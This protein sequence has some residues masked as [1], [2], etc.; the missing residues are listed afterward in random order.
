VTHRDDQGVV[1]TIIFGERRG[2][3]R[4]FV[5][6]TNV[7]EFCKRVG[8]LAHCK[9]V[10]P[11]SATH[12]SCVLVLPNIFSAWGLRARDHT[13]GV[14]EQPRRRKANAP[15]VAPSEC[16]FLGNLTL[17]SSGVDRDH[18]SFDFDVVQS[19]G[20]RGDFVGFLV[21]GKLPQA[22]RPIHCPGTQHRAFFN[23]RLSLRERIK[24]R[25]FR[26]AKDDTDFPHDAN[27][28]QR[29]QSF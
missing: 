1:V 12:R 21:R 28:P 23:C 6:H 10:L 4:F 15:W 11:K 29:A 20:N 2:G 27:Q 25:H 14:H 5:S 16:H 8:P 13:I 19:L 18:R 26:G 17:T 7:H 22:D 24:T 3:P 9:K